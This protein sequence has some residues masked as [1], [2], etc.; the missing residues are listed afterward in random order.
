MQ[1]VN[2]IV[3]DIE[4]KINRIINRLDA[5]DA[6]NRKLSLDLGEKLQTIEMLQARVRLLEEENK[7]LKIART[8]TTGTDTSDTKKQIDQLVREIDTCISLLN[9]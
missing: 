5:T 9:G 3:S 2:Q 4:L 8:I 7:I 1:N 6:E